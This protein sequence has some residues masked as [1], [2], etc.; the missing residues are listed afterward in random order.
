MSN[1]IN[2]IYRVPFV[3]SPFYNSLKKDLYD[4]ELTAYSDSLNENGYVIVDLGIN[5][6]IIDQANAD[7]QDQID[8]NEF[9]TNSK[10]YHYND[11]PRIVEAWKFSNSIKEIVKN[12]KLS[13]ILRYCYQSEPIPFSTIN[14]LKGTEQPLHSDEIHFGSIPHGYLTGCWIALED[15]H[16]D[17]GPL[18]VGVKSHKLPLFSYESIGLE[19]PKTEKELKR[20]YTL[21]EEWAK[22]I[23]EDNDIEIKELPIKKGECIIWSS[24]LLHGAFSIKNKNLSRKSM[25]IHFHYE[26]CEKIFYPSYSNLEKGKFI[27]RSLHDLDIRKK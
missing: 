17:S 1:N 19:I 12:K 10:A 16:E 13:D 15:I 26:D 25:A 22:K 9:K 5:S 6:K 8:K 18:A 27:Y 4:N 14:F 24:N 3:N 11:S 21:Y 7:I 2:K 20:S 23:M